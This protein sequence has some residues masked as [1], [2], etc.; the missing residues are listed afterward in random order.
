MFTNGTDYALARKLSCLNDNEVFVLD[1]SDRLRL[2][3]EKLKDN[4]HEAYETN[5]AR[6]NTRIRETR[7]TPGQ[8]VYKR[9]FVLS[10][11]KQNI[12]SKFCKKF[13]KCRVSKVLG[14][15]MYL[16]ESLAGKDLGAWHAKDIKQ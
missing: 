4:L 14:N 10:D 7:F 11:F 3:R 13:I 9:N 15:N 5:A 1:H 8:E 2:M 12:N 6:Y 16:L